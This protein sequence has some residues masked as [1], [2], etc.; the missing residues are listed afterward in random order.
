MEAHRALSGL[1]ADMEINIK[2]IAKR[3]YL[4]PVGCHLGLPDFPPTAVLYED[5]ELTPP[6]LVFFGMKE[7]DFDRLSAKMRQ[8]RLLPDALK[9]V[10]TGHNLAW[11]AL[12]LHR[13]LSA[14]REQIESKGS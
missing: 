10:V 7:R 9:A 14:E 12:F 2:K 11:N 6:M 8:A 13:E 4:Q 5:E 3:R 1:A